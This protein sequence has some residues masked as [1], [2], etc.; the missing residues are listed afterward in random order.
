VYLRSRADCSCRFAVPT[1]YVYIWLD[2]SIL[3]RVRAKLILNVITIIVDYQQVLGKNFVVKKSTVKNSDSK[4]D[5]SIRYKE[6][7]NVM[8]N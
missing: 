8:H 3:G 1:M 7:Y 2:T 5:I 4:K 6:K